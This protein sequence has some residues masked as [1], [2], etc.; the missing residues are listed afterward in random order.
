MIKVMT[1][2]E[3][4]NLAVPIKLVRNDAD[5]HPAAKENVNSESDVNSFP[6]IDEENIKCVIM[7][8]NIQR[9]FTDFARTGQT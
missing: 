9:T 2:E 8:L 6:L 5:I 3:N 4:T 1:E 7:C